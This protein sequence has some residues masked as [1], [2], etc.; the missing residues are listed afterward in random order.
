MP[1]S[2]NLS[3]STSGTPGQ[4]TQAPL[5]RCRNGSSALTRPPGLCFHRSVPSGSRSR[6]TGS[7]VATTM[8]SAPPLLL[9]SVLTP[10][11]PPLYESASDISQQ[12][13]GVGDETCG[14]THV[15]V[16]KYGL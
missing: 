8:N 16:Q 14:V 4:P 9:I 12:I 2:V 10:S 6:S 15:W 5:L 3:T 1:F 11:V 7:R 13:A